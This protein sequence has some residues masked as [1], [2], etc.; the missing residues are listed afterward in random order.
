MNITRENIDNLNA[1]L[2]INIVK[3]DYEEKVETVL[4]DYRK[5][6][7]I[8]G[9]RPGMVPIGMVRK[10][11][12]HAVQIDEI[13]KIVTDSIQKYI[14]DEKL[15]ILGDPMPSDE[16][17]NIDFDTQEEFTFSFELGLAPAIELN[18]SKN[19]IVTFHEISIDEKM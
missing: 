5:K 14:T 3:P 7:T 16:Q 15:E 13:N 1:V 2:K 9:F 17:E 8:K 6:A 19:N 10:I 11:Y 12:G 18:L 4:K